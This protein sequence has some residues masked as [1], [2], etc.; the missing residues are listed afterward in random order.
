MKHH[1]Q[2][3][4][5][6]QFELFKAYGKSLF[7]FV[8]TRTGGISNGEYASFNLGEYSGDT[9]ENI[10][11]N[12]QILADMLNVGQGRI[13]LPHQ[14]HE[15]NILIVDKAFLS[16]PEERQKENM[17][18]VDALITSEKQACIAVSTADCVPVLVFDPVEK[19]LASVH[20]GWRGTLSRIVAKVIRRMESEYSCNPS[21]MFAGIA[22]SI[23]QSCFEVGEDVAGIFRQQG[24]PM[25]KIS[26]VNSRTDKTHIDLP[27]INKLQLMGSGIPPHQIELSGICTTCDEKRFFSAR[28]QGICSGRMATGGM[29]I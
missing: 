26:V 24:F 16:L 4:V 25:D 28:R 3:P 21:N 13:F 20:A 19:V 22:P 6:L 29:L 17:Q 5:L 2:Y 9:P 15:D 14:T 7:H 1:P 23:S 12:R 18:G 10:G 11:E 27:L 8:T